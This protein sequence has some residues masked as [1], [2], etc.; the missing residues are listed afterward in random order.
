[1]SIFIWLDFRKKSKKFGYNLAEK[2]KGG[3]YLWKIMKKKKQ[4]WNL[5]PRV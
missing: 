3:H 2:V 5:L 4:I 1:M